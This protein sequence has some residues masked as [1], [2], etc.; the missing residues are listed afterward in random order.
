M[1]KAFKKAEFSRG[2]FRR[3]SESEILLFVSRTLQS[4]SSELAAPDI[5]SKLQNLKDILDR[6][7]IDLLI[8]LTRL[9]RIALLSL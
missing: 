6:Q 3:L 7:E 8:G 5:F 4:R 1:L 9:A 2:P